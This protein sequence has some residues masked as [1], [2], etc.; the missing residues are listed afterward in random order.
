MKKVGYCQKRKIQW[1]RIQSLERTLHIH[2]QPIPYKG[3]KAIK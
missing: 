1:N 3:A 2:G